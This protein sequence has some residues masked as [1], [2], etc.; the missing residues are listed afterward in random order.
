MRYGWRIQESQIDDEKNISSHKLEQKEQKKKKKRRKKKENEKEREIL[1]KRTFTYKLRWIGGEEL[2][3]YVKK[4]EEAA[5]IFRRSWR[6]LLAIWLVDLF[7]I[8]FPHWLM[9]WSPST[10]YP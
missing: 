10:P 5:A 6:Q 2:M 3:I 4:W 7:G 1:Q 9:A 8:K